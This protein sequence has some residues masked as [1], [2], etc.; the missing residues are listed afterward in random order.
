MSEKKEETTPVLPVLCQISARRSEWRNGF[1][2]YVFQKRANL[3]AFAENITMK[4]M[5]ME[6]AI[7]FSPKPTLQLDAGQIQNL[8]D[9]LWNAGVRPSNGTASTGQIA[10]TD[11]HL[12]DLRKIAFHL[13]K[14]KSGQET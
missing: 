11:N 5:P 9:D 4:D 12:A 3:V 7:G 2:L 10:A 1:D 8:M 6:E 14:I 13:L